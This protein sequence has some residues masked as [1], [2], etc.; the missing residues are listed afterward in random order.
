MTVTLLADIEGYSIV[1]QKAGLNLTIDG[2]GHTLQGQIIIDGDGRASGTETLTIK[3]VKFEDDNSHFCPGT[4]AFVIVPSTKDANKPYTTGKYNYAHNITVKD[5]SFSGMYGNTVAFKSNSGAGAY[6]VTLDNLTGTNL[7]SLAQFTGTTGATITN[8]TVTNAESAVNVNGGTGDYIISD[9][10]FNVSDTGYG[11]RIKNS[12]TAN[13]VLS[14]NSIS[15]GKA[16]VLGSDATINVQSGRYKGVIEKNTTSEN[17]KI[18]IT[19]GYFTVPPKYDYCGTVNGVHLYAIENTN[20]ATKTDYPYTVGTGAVAMVNEVGYFSFANAA[21]ARTSN[22]DVIKL[23]EN[24]TDEY[25]LTAG[26][27]NEILKVQHDGKTLTV[28]APEG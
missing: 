7:H 25:T 4:D 19:D 22:D 15:A 8:C 13:A 2:D 21:A 3:N 20:E 26:E 12:S 17:A 27:P 5:C 14:A 1:H 16:F 28:K 24:I 18:I 10:T 11:V 9:N 6:N 23:L